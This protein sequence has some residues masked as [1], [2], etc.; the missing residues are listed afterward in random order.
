TCCDDPAIIIGVPLF[1]AHRLARD[2][3]GKPR[4]RVP[5]A[6]PA[7]AFQRAALVE[8]GRIDAV[9]ADD[10]ARHIERVA[11]GGARGAAYL[12]SECRRRRRA[13]H[14]R[15]ED[16]MSHGGSPLGCPLPIPFASWPLNKFRTSPHYGRTT[17]PP[18]A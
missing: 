11:I 10:D 15:G 16:D 6:G 13:Q 17:R 5:A 3:G 7:G 14:Q 9:Q 4:G 12:L 2:E 8:L 18:D 1:A